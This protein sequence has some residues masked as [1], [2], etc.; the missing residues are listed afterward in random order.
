MTR[1][2]SCCTTAHLL[3]LHR[4]LPHSHAVNETD[5]PSVC[6][7]LPSLLNKPHLTDLRLGHKPSSCVVDSAWAQ[8]GLPVS[9]PKAVEKEW[10]HMLQHMR[11]IIGAKLERL[12]AA[13]PA[14]T[15]DCSH[16][17]DA[18]RLLS[19]IAHAATKHAG[20]ASCA[21]AAQAAAALSH[22]TPAA[23]AAAVH[24]ICMS[25][26]F[27]QPQHMPELVEQLR[28]FPALKQLDVSA[29]PA[30]D[31]A[32]VSAIVRAVSGTAATQHSR[33]TDASTFHF[34][35]VFRVLLLM[36]V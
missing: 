36:R 15:L 20:T 6:R 16:L 21:A 24:T 2:A 4:P 17:F 22:A 3:L 18:Q 30:L 29:N 12:L 13:A 19:V 35:H 34:P 5:V 33:F 7:L 23:A 8:A 28:K 25:G 31:V 11:E 14:A 27:L 32:A 9:T 1:D 10:T 26:N